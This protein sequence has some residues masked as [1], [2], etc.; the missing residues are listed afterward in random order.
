MIIAASEP[1]TR[2]GC[3]HRFDQHVPPPMGCVH[4]MAFEWPAFDCLCPAYLPAGS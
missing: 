3:G 1:C 2:P 4:I